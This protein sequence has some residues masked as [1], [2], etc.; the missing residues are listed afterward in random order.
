MGVH[1]PMHPGHAP[2]E[3]L[4]TRGLLYFNSTSFWKM[5]SHKDAVSFGGGVRS[6]WGG[7]A[8]NKTRDLDRLFCYML[9][10]EVGEG[11][12]VGGVTSSCT[13]LVFFKKNILYFSF[14]IFLKL[15]FFW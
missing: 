10:G 15:F 14:F 5:R 3:A 11:A 12:G 4:F 2:S 13:N 1:P 9:C 8:E 6:L 7:T